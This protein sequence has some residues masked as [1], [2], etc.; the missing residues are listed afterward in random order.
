MD[1]HYAEPLDVPAPARVALLSPS[2]FTRRFRAVFGETPHQYLYRRRIERA[3][4]LLRTTDLPVTEIGHGVGYASLG[5]FT[6]TFRRLTGETPTAFRRRGAVAPVAGS[7]APG[8]GR[9]GAVR[10]A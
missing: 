5:T 2:H 6:R 1:R 7:V 3:Q 9:A 8:R 4:R 10:D